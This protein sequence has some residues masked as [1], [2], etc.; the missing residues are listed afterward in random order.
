MTTGACSEASTG[1][2]S[3]ESGRIVVV[4]LHALTVI[5]CIVAVVALNVPLSGLEHSTDTVSSFE[6]SQDLVIHELL[7]VANRLVLQWARVAVLG[8]AGIPW[9]FEQL[10]VG[11]GRDPPLVALQR[12]DS[13]QWRTQHLKRRLSH[14]ALPRGKLI[15]VV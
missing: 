7:P 15:R 8:D 1:L 2:A 13:L 4:M 3:P 14:E 11:G 9:C 12:S 10:P 6:Q 5:V